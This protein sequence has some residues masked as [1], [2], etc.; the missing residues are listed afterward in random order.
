MTF[1]T[2]LWRV[3]SVR[4]CCSQMPVTLH[5]LV[6]QAAEATFADQ[7][8]RTLTHEVVKMDHTFNV[9]TVSTLWSRPVIALMQLL[10]QKMKT[11]SPSGDRK[12]TPVQAYWVMMDGIG[13]VLAHKFVASK[14][15]ADY[16]DSLKGLQRRF[17]EQ[18]CGVGAAA[19]LQLLS[20]A[21]MPDTHA[22][23]RS[24]L[25]RLEVFPFN[26]SGLFSE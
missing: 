22:V 17:A 5:V 14:S 24:V 2:D 13:R 15:P 11:D 20:F 1:L 19:Q 25:R 23:H 10:S 9:A 18:V 6:I 7:F 3:H 4:G 21:E 8:M 16:Q 12:D 26:I